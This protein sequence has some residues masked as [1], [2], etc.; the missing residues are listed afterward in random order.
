AAA[1]ELHSAYGSIHLLVNN[2]GVMEPPFQRTEDGY[3]LTFAT[4]H[5]GHFAL[6]GLLLDRFL[7]TPGSR[8]VT[9]SS[10]GHA[11]G[12][13]RFDDLQSERD[14]RPAQAYY[15]SKLANLL[16]TYELDPSPAS[17][18]RSDDRARLPPWHR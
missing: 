11:A 8:I 16:F 13:M 18:E 10:E 9:V 2:G 7:E 12:V 6:T 15:Q 17:R 1:S 14:Y 5:L 3:E 4:N